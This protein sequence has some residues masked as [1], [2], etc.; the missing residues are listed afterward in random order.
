MGLIR[1]LLALA[2]VVGHSWQIRGLS[3]VTPSFAVSIFFAISGFYMALV[4]NSKYDVSLR[5][6]RLFWSNRLLRL[7][8][9][10]WIVFLLT[11]VVYGG[12]VALDRDHL[13]R[14]SRLTSRG[15][16]TRLSFRSR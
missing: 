5:G 11:L 15:S 9:T 7:F 6:S 12:S 3:F 14:P 4:L 13:R 8:P 2:V 10:Y 16:S 1:L